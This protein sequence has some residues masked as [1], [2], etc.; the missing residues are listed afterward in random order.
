MNKTI[1]QIMVVIAQF[2]NIIYIIFYKKTR[3]LLN[4]ESGFFL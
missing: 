2:L 4:V 1:V 3:S